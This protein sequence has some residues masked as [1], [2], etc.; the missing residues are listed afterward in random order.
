MIC[1]QT[2][3]LR[4]LITTKFKKRI[5]D[6]V[7]ALKNT[8]VNE[9]EIRKLA[10]KLSRKYQKRHF[11]RSFKNG[12][13]YRKEKRNKSTL[14]DYR[15]DEEILFNPIIDIDYDIQKEPSQRKKKNYNNNQ[16]HDT[17]KKIK[18]EGVITI[19]FDPVILEDELVVWGE[20]ENGEKHPIY[21]SGTV[22]STGTI[23]K[24]LEIK[25]N[26]GS[27]WKIKFR[28]NQHNKEY[29]HS[30]IWRGKIKMHYYDSS[31]TNVK[32]YVRGF[33]PI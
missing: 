10:C 1:F 23:T 15:S 14:T 20:D 3:D 31:P 30:D 11:F 17:D 25:I 33:S 19:T 16:D 12:N 21:R 9:D 2:L 26:A 13:F 22:G 32:P 27:G 7:D 4:S 8:G 24:N 28:V 5:S 6:K 29:D 18:G